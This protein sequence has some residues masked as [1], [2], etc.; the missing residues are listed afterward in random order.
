MTRQADHPGIQ[1]EIF[2]AKLGTDPQFLG[3]LKHLR[4]QFKVTESVSAFAALGRQTVQI[5]GGC[6]LYGFQIEFSRSPSDHKSQMIRRT[7]R[8][9]D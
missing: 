1:T 8:R 9:T 3:H 6:Q 4:F 2:S 7:G 5:A